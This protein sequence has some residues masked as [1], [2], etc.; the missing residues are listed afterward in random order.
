[1]VKSTVFFDVGRTMMYA[2]NRSR[3]SEMF[4][5]VAREHGC[6]SSVGDVEPFMAEV[7]SFYEEEYLRDGDF[8]CSHER[9][10]ALSGLICIAC[11]RM[12]TGF[13]GRARCNQS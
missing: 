5:A 11:S 13:E 8:W 10:V 2:A 4:A 6:D 1:M 3:V 12:R 7:D 9:A